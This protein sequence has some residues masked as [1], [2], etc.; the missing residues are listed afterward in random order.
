MK[1]WIIYGCMLLL[2]CPL[3]VKA[4]QISDITTN[5]EEVTENEEEKKENESTNTEIET[6]TTTESNEEE[7]TDTSLIANAKAGI[8]IEASTGEII[9]EKNKQKF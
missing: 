2:M 9:F 4:E 3:F 8:L 7:T 1:K 6:N 5:Q